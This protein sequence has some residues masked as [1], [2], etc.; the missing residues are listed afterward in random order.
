M[1]GTERERRGA[2]DERSAALATQRRRDG[3]PHQPRQR[4]QRAPAVLLACI[5]ITLL[6]LLLTV[7]LLA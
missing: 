6:A 5:V 2:H 1:K 7:Q 4:K 3:H